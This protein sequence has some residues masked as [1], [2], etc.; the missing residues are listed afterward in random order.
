MFCTRWRRERQA[1]GKNLRQKEKK[2]KD[3]AVQ[4]EDERKQAQQYKDQ[5]RPRTMQRK[6]LSFTRAQSTPLRSVQ[7]EKGN[8]RL[9]QLK[10]QLEEAEEESQRMAAARRK[11]QRELEEAS[12]AND[13]LSREVASLRSKLRYAVGRSDGEVGGA[14]TH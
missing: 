9:K 8:V 5:V 3:L 6:R 1:N 11:L 13:T 2:L 12:E 7:A 4:M 14:R 10:H